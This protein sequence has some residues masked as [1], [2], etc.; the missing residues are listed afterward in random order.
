V[1]ADRV[2]VVERIGQFDRRRRLTDGAA[3]RVCGF[4]SVPNLNSGTP[5]SEL[6]DPDL[7][8]CFERDWPAAEFADFDVEEVAQRKRDLGLLGLSQD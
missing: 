8:R 3:R 2:Q 1:G 6:D 4:T 7:R 5:S